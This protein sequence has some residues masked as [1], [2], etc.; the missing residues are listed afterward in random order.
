MTPETWKQR[1]GEATWQHICRDRD[2]QM[3]ADILSRA[4]E[5][6][7]QAPLQQPK[8][9]L[10]GRAVLWPDGKEPML[11]ADGLIA[12]MEARGH[13][14]F[15]LRVRELIEAHR[16]ALMPRLQESILA[17]DEQ[18]RAKG[19]EPL[20]EWA[21]I[22]PFAGGTGQGGTGYPAL[23]FMRELVAASPVPSIQSIT[24]RG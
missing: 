24:V 17:Y 19:I 9:I 7:F 4:T 10:G 11:T 23:D 13:G 5:L 8:H 18:C 21:N 6:G 12:Y 20:P 14:F 3:V 16:G 15:L 1:L 22:R 2:S